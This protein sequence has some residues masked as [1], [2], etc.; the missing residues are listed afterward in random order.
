MLGR[1][2]ML[3]GGR[4]RLAAVGAVLA[5][6]TACAAGPASANP[7][8]DCFER[9]AVATRH[10]APH[11]A[12][13]P[14][15]HRVRHVGPRRPKPHKIAA[16]RAVAAYAHR[17]HYVLRP[18]ACGT[19]EAQMS[20]LPGLVTPDAP[21]LL[22]AEIA[23]PP[24]AAA[25]PELADKGLVPLP[26]GPGGDPSAISGPGGVSPG[27]GFVF[28]GSGGPSGPGGPG[29]PGQP[30]VLPPTGPDNP[31]VTP[32]PVLPPVTPPDNPPTGPGNPPLT[33]PPGQPPVG[34]GG[35][36][37]IPEPATWA[38]LTIGFFGLGAALRRRRARL[39]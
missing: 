28:P 1:G 2:W 24:A 18:R 27:G 12:R 23:G 30:P 36:T 19:N 14:A 38:M 32:P 25:L 16:A 8:T 3:G 34:P 5:G 4:A 11:R 35:P 9:I 20:P 31:P 17:T 37:V 22:L 15:V 7:L 26:T 10:V 39:A 13:P 29:G 21:E 6:A 33:P